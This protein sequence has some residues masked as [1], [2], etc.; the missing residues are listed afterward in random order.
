MDRIFTLMYLRGAKFSEYL[1]DYLDYLGYTDEQ[2]NDL[3]DS[4]ME[5]PNLTQILDD[6]IFS[7]YCSCQD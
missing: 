1:E 2:V 5:H 6:A 3:A 7:H 4:L